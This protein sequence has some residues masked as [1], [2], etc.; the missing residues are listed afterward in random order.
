MKPTPV[1]LTCHVGAALS[2]A[3][4]ATDSDPAKAPG[5]ASEN[6]L[7]TWA[8]V[9]HK[10]DQDEVSGSCLQTGLAL[11]SASIWN[12]SQWMALWH[13]QINLKKILNI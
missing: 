1:T 12:M 7:D 13:S 6:G 11:V 8:P 2:L 3:F 9:T 5:N 10:G 4:S